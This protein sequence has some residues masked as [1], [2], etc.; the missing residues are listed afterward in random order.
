MCWRCIG[1]NLAD[2]CQRHRLSD[3]VRMAVIQPPSEASRAMFLCTEGEKKEK[4]PLD[5]G[6]GKAAVYTASGLAH[7][8]SDTIGCLPGCFFVEA[9]QSNGP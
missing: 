6:G 4:S 2:S 7:P 1:V 9:W 8:H 3:A 5:G